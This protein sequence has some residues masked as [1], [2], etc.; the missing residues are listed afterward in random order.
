MKKKIQL[1]KNFKQN[2][3]K[4]EHLNN[5]LRA[6]R[7]VNKLITKEKDLAMA[8]SSVSVLGNALRIQRVKLK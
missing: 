1:L 7:N 2:Q 5:V 6:I 3:A 4:I 8:F